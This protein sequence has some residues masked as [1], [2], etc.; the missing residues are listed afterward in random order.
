MMS[1]TRIAPLSDRVGQRDQGYP[2]ND[3]VRDEEGI[4][5]PPRNPPNSPPPPLTI[6][7]PL[8]FTSATPK[9]TAGYPPS[10]GQY[11]F[12]RRAKAGALV[13]AG[14]WL[15]GFCHHPVA[16][17]RLSR[18]PWGLFAGSLLLFS[19]L[20]L[21]RDPASIRRRQL[22]TRSSSSPS[23]EH[24]SA[25]L[26]PCRHPLISFHLDRRSLLEDAHTDT[27]RLS[28]RRTCRSEDERVRDRS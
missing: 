5:P 24:S 2:A 14:S 10:Y 9:W 15:A 7:R 1:S 13:V 22:A 23:R 28:R 18:A 3:P 26:V 12:I 11:F 16:R 17:A 20:Y 25:F 27:T 19:T 8:C 21:E 6:S 4:H